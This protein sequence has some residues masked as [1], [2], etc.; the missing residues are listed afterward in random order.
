M[1]R[2]YWSNE[3]WLRF[4]ACCFRNGP[5]AKSPPEVSHN[6]KGKVFGGRFVNHHTRCPIYMPKILG[7][8]NLIALYIYTTVLYRFSGFWFRTFQYAEHHL[9]LMDQVYQIL[10]TL[11]F[12]HFKRPLQGYLQIIELV[13][14]RVHFHSFKLPLR[15]NIFSESMLQK[16]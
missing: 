7:P 14:F 1:V 5:V 10:G 3:V 2:L 12:C 11:Y 8:H 4:S 13:M 9:M 15:N 6:I 16:K